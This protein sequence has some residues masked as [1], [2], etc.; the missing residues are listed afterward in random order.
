SPQY[1]QAQQMLRQAAAIEMGPG[2]QLPQAKAA[3][4]YLK[5]QAALVMQADSVSVD[6]NTGIQTKQL[7]G[8]RLN[9]ANPNAHY[10]WND[11]HNAGVD[12][13]GTLPP[14]TPRAPSLT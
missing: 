3:V 11:Q 1:H 7:T 10:V 12:E 6:P 13:T 4:A 14:V 8:E 2:G 5:S 9:A